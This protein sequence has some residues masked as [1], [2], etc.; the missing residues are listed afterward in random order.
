MGLGIRFVGERTA[1]LLAE[2]FGS[3][4][5]LQAASAEE[6]ERVE[7]VGPRISQAIL[8]FFAQPANRSLVES[9]R[10]AGVDMTAEKK[11][12]STQLAGLLFV[13]TGTLPTLSREEAKRRIEAAGGKTAGSVSKKTSYVVAGEEAGSKLDKALE[14]KLPVIDEAGLLALLETSTP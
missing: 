2:E 1:E 11:Q 12:R 13:L 4:D 5:A 3:I 10:A 8:E 9:L 14:L 7:E 6:L